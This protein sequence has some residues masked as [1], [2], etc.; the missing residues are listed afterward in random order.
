MNAIIAPSAINGSR[1][2]FFER[3][4]G[5]I[6]IY[7]KERIQYRFDF[8]M[9]LIACI[10]Y[11]AMYF[12][13]WKV[14]YANSTGMALPWQELI[15]YV[16]VGQAVNMARYS[17]AERRPAHTMS[18]R[19]Q[20]GDIALDLLRPVGF[21]SQRFIE[22]FSFWI[23]EMLWVNIPMLIMFTLVLGISPPAGIMQGMA[24][25]LSMLLAFLVGFGL[26]VIILTLAF[27]TRNVFGTQITKRAIVDIFAG[28]LIPFQLFPDWF[29]SVVEHLPFKG[30]AYIPLSIWTGRI[31]GTDL[32]WALLEQAG[33]AALLVLLSL[34]IWKRA[35]KII[36]IQGG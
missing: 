16:M 11:S 25:A 18:I 22:G 14:I 6:F 7:F 29:R 9:T 15:T 27:W 10:L 34:V 23:T 33:W 21:Q 24:F 8:V 31:G 4:S 36:T 19:I 30:I 28:T 13:V 32:G 5:L 1:I 12:M 3:W 35:M 26:N 17:P 20:N 2:G